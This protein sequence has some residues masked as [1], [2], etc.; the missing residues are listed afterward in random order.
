VNAAT[1]VRYCEDVTRTR[2]RNFWYGIRLLPEPKRQA[3]ASIYAMA[4]R[5]DDIGDGTA[6]TEQKRDE[7]DRVAASFAG[8]SPAADDPV[9]A[10]VALAAIRFPLPMDAFGDLVAGVRMDLDDQRY[11]TW[12]DLERYCRRVAG[13]IGR[14][15]LGVFGARDPDGDPVLADDLGVAMQLTNVLRDVRED[16]ERG[17]VYLPEEDLKRFDLT[18]DD[19]SAAS[20]AGPQVESLVRFEV[21]RARGWFDRSLG[22]LGHLDRRSAA[23]A[24]AMAGIYRR[25]LERIDAAPL[26]VLD[27]R[28]S[29]PG[30]EKAWV[31]ARALAGVSP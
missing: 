25:L 31:A 16:R 30:W 18:H 28:L 9:L 4:R 19:L 29:L 8:A 2:A 21:E 27:R 20:A 1:A 10:A 12:D 14:L 15:S 5:I 6:P 24:G 7:L 11:A 13:S 26:D 3:L 23:C 22:L 17:R